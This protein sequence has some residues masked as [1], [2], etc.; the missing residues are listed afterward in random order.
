MFNPFAY[1]VRSRHLTTFALTIITLAAALTTSSAQTPN[2]KQY[3]TTM[4]D[5]NERAN[6]EIDPSSLGL[7]I[8]ISLADFP[9]RG[10]SLPVKLRYSS[11]IW[12][13]KFN[14]TNINPGDGSI[15]EHTLWA[16]WYSNSVAGWTSTLN[17]PY[18]EDTGWSEPF[19]ARFGS[20]GRAWTQPD[21][22]APWDYTFPPHTYVSENCNPGNDNWQC[23]VRPLQYYANRVMLHMPDGSSHEMRQDDLVYFGNTGPSNR[24]YYSVDGS[25]IKYDHVNQVVFLPDGSRYM[26]NTANGAQYIDR[27]GNTLNYNSSSGQWTDT[28]GRAISNPLGGPGGSDYYWTVPTAQG[29]AATYVFRWRSLGQT[30]TDTTQALNYIGPYM[31][32]YP[33]QYPHLVPVGGPSLFGD[34][35]TGGISPFAW[36]LSP[37]FNG[38]P[39]ELFNP[40]VLSEIELPNGQKYRFTY[41]VYAEIDKV[42]LPTGGYR[43][44][45]YDTVPASDYDAFN[46]KAYSQ[47]NRGVVEAWESVTGDPQEE[48]PVSWT[49]QPPASSGVNYI[50]TTNPDGTYV[51]RYVHIRD[52]LNSKFNASPGEAKAGRIYDEQYFSSNGQMLRRVLSDWAYTGPL[53]LP[54]NP[55]AYDPSGMEM[56]SRDARV[57]RQVEILLDTG[58]DALAKTTD[59][60]YDNDLNVIST[61]QYEYVSVVQST[62]QTG[63]TSQIPIGALLRAEETTFLVNDPDISQ[64]TKDAYRERHLIALP[65]KTLVKNGSGSVVAATQYKYDESAYPLTT[66]STVS[67]WTDPQNTNRGNLT[68]VRHWQNFNYSTGVQQ[69]WTDWTSGTWIETHTWYDQCGNVVKVRDGNNNDTVSSYA[70]NFYGSSPQNTYAYPT[71]VTT[72][73]P[74]LTTI[75]KYDFNTGLVREVTDPNNVKTRTDYNDSFNRPTKTVRAEGTNVESQTVIQYEDVIRR[76]TITSDKDVLGES[77]AGNGLKSAVINDGFGR[78]TRNAIYEGNTGAGNTWAIT[79]TQ[80]D[81]F[82]RVSQVSNPY[83]AADPGSAS[84]P[85][86]L[87]TTTEYDSL[88]RPIKVT[89]PDLAQVNTAYNGNQV[90]VTDQAGKKRS[91]ETDALGRLTKVIEDPGGLSYET[92]Y[93]YDALGNLRQVTQG[94]QYRWFAYDSLSRLIRAKNPEQDVNANPNISY[95]DPVTGHSGWSMAYSYDANGNLVSKTDARDFTTTYG[96]DALNR[97]TSV[98]YSNTGYNPDITRFYDNPDPLSYGKGRYWHDYAGGN[99]SADPNIDHTAIDSYDPLGRPKTK[100][101]LFKRNG[102]VGP[103]YSTI[104]TYDL[105]GNVKTVRYPSDR[106]VNYSYDSAGRLYS[107]S[108]NLGGTPLTYADM[109]DYN[110]AGQMI[111]ERFG[112]NT[113]LYHRSHYNNRLQLVSTRLGD[114]ETDEL[115][116]NRGAFDFLYGTTAVASGNIFANDTDNNGNLRRQTNYVPLAGSGD[117]IPQRDDYTYDALNRINSF[118]EAQRNSSGQWTPNVAWQNFSYDP[119][120]NR[121][122]TGASGGV[123]NYNPP[124]DQATNRTHW[125]GYDTAGNVT[126]DP[127]TGGEMMYDAENRL[128][129]AA[130]VGGGIYVY[131]ADGKRVSRPTAGGQETWYVYGCGGELLAEYTAGA[132]PTAPLKEYGY[133]GGQLLIVAESGSGGGVSFVK[134]T[135]KSSADLI[136]KAGVEADSDANGLLVVNE[137]VAALGI[138][139]GHGSITADFSDSDNTGT[140]MRGG[141]RTTVEEYGN[142]PSANGV[143]GE[144][145]AEHPA[146]VAPSPPQKE[147]GYRSGRSWTPVAAQSIVHVTPGAYQTPDPAGSGYLAVNSP[148][149]TEHGSTTAS[150]AQDIGQIKS[151]RWFAFQPVGGQIT[152]ITLKFNWS[153]SGNLFTNAPN[154]GD[155]AYANATFYI[156]YSTNNGSNWPTAIF[157]RELSNISG[158]GG[159]NR[160]FSDSGSF[161]VDLP[162][163]TPINQIMIYDNISA[164]ASSNWFEGHASSSAT[165]T[166]RVWNIDL[167]VE[168]NPAGP[169]TVAPLSPA[170]GATNVNADANV[171]MTFSKAMDAAT[172]NGST[173]EL[174]DPGNALVPATVSYNAAS[175]TA[176]LD[177]T[178]S[179]ARGVTYTA[180]VRGGGADPRVKDVAGNALAADVTWTFTTTQSGI[181]WLVTDHLGSTRMVIDETGSLAGIK[182]NDFA[183]FG[184]VLTAGPGIRSEN[185]GYSGDSVRQ[186]FGS[187]ERDNETGLDFFEARYFSSVQGRFTSP[188]EFQGGPIELFS[189]AASTNPTFY[190]DLTN[191]QSLNK[192]QYCYNNPLRYTD[193]NGHAPDGDGIIESIKNYLWSLLKDKVNWKTEE[194]PKRSDPSIAGAPSGD[195]IVEKHFESLVTISEINADIIMALDPIGTTS[196]LMNY[197]KGDNR[198]VAIAAIGSAVGVFGQ[199]GKAGTLRASEA[200]AQIATGAAEEGI[201]VTRAA[202]LRATEVVIPTRQE[203]EKLIGA[204]GGVVQRVDKG[205]NATVSTHNFPHIN[206]TVGNQRYT[207][208]VQSVGKEFDRTGRYKFRGGIRQPEQ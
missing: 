195:K 143:G 10:V 51:R 197:I 17:V 168:T 196:V 49:F 120:G 125:L 162:A 9:G 70:D 151:C 46:S 206:Y 193:P 107:F 159:E 92:T 95:T 113:R 184:E 43:R 23:E 111:K 167:E 50:T 60:L 35:S 101:Q 165:L 78:T 128:L 199:F 126:N 22:G 14:G 100:R 24:M 94:A 44:Y 20:I 81:V 203:A 56:T 88:G 180:R 139:E 19:I 16:E 21:D 153:I 149:N 6:V 77:A 15:S 112:T 83:R 179:L 187:K 110:A 158:P 8:S 190:A 104:Q 47:A 163:N 150:A 185:N 189:I 102:I 89:T 205:A 202:T 156:E 182:R 5:L 134:P 144:L 64:A 69:S 174:R 142:A 124:Y 29:G 82:G 140:L 54:F 186:K 1:A 18:V 146:G 99:W 136:G 4:N 145:L 132:Q 67:S 148:L 114:S 171:T 164:Q 121:Q 53:Q 127:T 73:G 115:S 85:A 87:W 7:N 118:T 207:V 36:V 130:S 183:P 138:N 79:D 122:I 108:G 48:T 135:L 59:Y 172:V 38:D 26:L 129:T 155:F 66:Y 131:N 192:Y 65:S 157:R 178:A 161:S 141:P 11:K 27:N 194:E 33:I 103:T 191:P 181:K 98:D 72:P 25:R 31:L 76:V 97:N 160:P 30:L 2:G 80:Y 39:P 169:P 188:D 105:A 123:S 90:T 42:Y 93:L 52:P 170:A 204:A 173:V 119:Y 28:L 117:V 32:N 96:Y 13:I 166:A 201:T 86:G 55:Q 75:T 74:A 154:S 62:A 109:I 57:T 37:R 137:P 41:N 116:W 3:T 200:L 34:G 45:R 40:G 147:Y 198:G 91:S 176:T 152:R 68:T 12:R 71:S 61:K 208:R 63:N 84:P 58:G 177:P 133:R 106:E 175:F